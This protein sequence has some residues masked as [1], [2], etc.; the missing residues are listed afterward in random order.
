LAP[1]FDIE[2]IV[3]S[4]EDLKHADEVAG[5]GLAH[6]ETDFLLHWLRH[7]AIS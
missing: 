7:T 6:E 5:G 4:A 3:V 1:R 2:G